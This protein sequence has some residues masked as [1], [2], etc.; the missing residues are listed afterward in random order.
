[1]PQSFTNTTQS[2]AIVDARPA[3]T[4]YITAEHFK[5]KASRTSS[6]GMA[7]RHLESRS[8]VLTSGEI[9]DLKARVEYLELEAQNNI[10]L[11]SEM[12][13]NWCRVS[14]EYR[15]LQQDLNR[16][17]MECNELRQTVRDLVQFRR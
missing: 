7:S 2:Y 5:H 16:V 1:M 3:T 11:R 10:E 15:K 9:T 4:P 14:A 8:T 6:P 13:Q 17:S 12:Q